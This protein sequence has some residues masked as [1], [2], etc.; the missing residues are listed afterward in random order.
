MLDVTAEVVN[1][2]VFRREFLRKYFPED[3]HGN[4][5]IEFLELKH[6]NLSITEYATRFVELAKFYPH[7]SETTAEFLKCIKFENGLRPEIKQAIGY[8]HIRRFPELV[9]NCRIYEDDSKARST[10]YKGLSE[11]RGKQ[12][13]NSGKRYNAPADK[14]KQ[15]STDGKRS[16]EGGS[17]TPLKCHR[18][19]ELGHRVSECKSAMKKCYKCGKL[20]LIVSSMNGEMVIKTLVKG[21]M[22]TTSVCLTCPLLIFD[23]DF[24][25]DLICLPLE[26]LDVILRMNWLEFNHVHINCYNK[27]V[28]FITP[29]EEEKVVWDFLEVF[30]DDISDVP[31]EREAEF[32]IDLEKKLYAKLSKCEFWLKEVSFLGHVI[33]GGGIDVDPSKVD[34][35]L[36]WEALKSVAEIRSF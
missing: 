14:G 2:A 9:N 34:A 11:R 29:G 5:E 18:C 36:Q 35:V 6:G 30:P 15:I 21:S 33:S 22:T 25:I 24:D 12:N 10:H 16:S 4:K 23:K 20:G 8:Q 26:N 17:L 1:W 19:G 31:P 13:M 7:Y 28:W 27:S 3:V 32:F